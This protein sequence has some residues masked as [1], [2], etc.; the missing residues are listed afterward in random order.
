MEIR[1]KNGILGV[2]GARWRTNRR[3]Q[4]LKLGLYEE[5]K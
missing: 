5:T 1:D 4:K 2:K 3:V